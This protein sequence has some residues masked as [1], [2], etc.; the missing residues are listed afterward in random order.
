MKY[1]YVKGVPK[2]HKSPRL[3]FFS[4]LSL[5]L[6]VFTLLWSFYPVMAYQIGE[7]VS[8][9]E[10]QS[11]LPK[12]ELSG[13]MQ[14]NLLTYN[15]SMAPYYSSYLKDFTT[16]ADWFPKVSQSLGRKNDIREYQIDIPKLGLSNLKVKIGG[17]DLSKS[18]VQFGNQV[19]PGEL[20][21]AVI[22][23]HSTLPQLF[24][25]D[26][27]RTIFTFLPDLERGDKIK[28]TF[29]GATYSYLVNEMFVVKPEEVWVLEEKSEESIL[30]LITCVPPGTYWKRLVVKA[31]LEGI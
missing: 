9:S 21:N 24:K 7:I 17:D 15:D 23:G 25:A 18:L 28:V 1:C 14:K 26:D 3:V 31:K 29:N 12:S 30:S 2:R 19:L 20:G 4:S 5:V 13:A 22:L 27:Y 8:K 16:V 11:P 6:G 10:N